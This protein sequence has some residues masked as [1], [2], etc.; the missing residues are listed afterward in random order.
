MNAAY[1]VSTC[2]HQP[3]PE[4]LE[5]CA[6][7]LCSA[8]SPNRMAAMFVVPCL[9]C[10]SVVDVTVV[11]FEEGIL[12]QQQ[13]AAA[14][15]LVLWSVLWCRVSRRYGARTPILSILPAGTLSLFVMCVIEWRL[16]A[17]SANR[18][19]NLRFDRIRDTFQLVLGDV[20]LQQAVRVKHPFT[21]RSCHGPLVAPWI[22]M[23]QQE[24]M[25]D[26]L[27]DS[28]LITNIETEHAIE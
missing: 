4:H 17:A 23:S 5:Q 25:R 21:H 15:L 28:Q 20:V 2:H 22:D 3:D 13:H 26:R 14:L 12:H 7:L 9:W 10:M 1:L 27:T 18:C 8:S 24:A 11:M 19:L 6:V 16:C